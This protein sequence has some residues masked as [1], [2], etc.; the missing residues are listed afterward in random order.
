MNKQTPE[1]ATR[2]DT[3][4][5]GPALAA[6]KQPA[7]VPAVDV[8]EDA[9]GITLKA[10]MPGADR[11]SL[12]IDV[13]GDTLTLEAPFSLGESAGMQ[14]VYMEVR[15][16]RYRRSFTLSRELDTARIDATLRDGVLTL[17]LPKREEA[18][19]RRIDVRVG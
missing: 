18:H 10:D 12:A 6:D 19:P 8:T 5:Q 11:E 17:R 4:H 16:P 14:P 13:N 2:D 9:T 7:L 15:A 3:R 1:L